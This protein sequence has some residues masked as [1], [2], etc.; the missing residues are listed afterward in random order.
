MPRYFFH[1]TNGWRAVNDSD[2]VEHENNESARLEAAEMVS[3]LL[4][5]SLITGHVWDGWRVIVRDQNGNTIWEI[6]F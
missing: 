5:E 3:E 6:K 4:K 1:L 2:G